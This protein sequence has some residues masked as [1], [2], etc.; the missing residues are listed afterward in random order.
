PGDLAIGLSTSGRS[1]NVI[2]G[3]RQA[4][5][6]GLAAAALTGADG[7]D[8][9]GLARPVLRVPS[10]VTARIQEMHMLL[11]HLLCGALERALGL[12]EGD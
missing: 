4:G 11:G 5:A 6:L 1:P 2:A 12:V 8:L 9:P 3:L 10:R 7:G